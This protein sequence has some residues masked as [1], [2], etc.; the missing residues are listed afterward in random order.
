MNMEF[1]CGSSPKL[2]SRLQTLGYDLESLDYISQD[3]LS[4]TVQLGYNARETAELFIRIKRAIEHM[5]GG[6]LPD[7]C[8]YE[9]NRLNP[10]RLCVTRKSANKSIF[11]RIIAGQTLADKKN[12]LYTC[13]NCPTDFCVKRYEAR[14]HFQQFHDN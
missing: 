14:E 1:L 13:E 3:F 11:F 7:L 10:T 4:L 12:I 6:Q 8:L 2:M 9:N 5:Q